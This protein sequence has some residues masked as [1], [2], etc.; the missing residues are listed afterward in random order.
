[1]RTAHV[2][3]SVHLALLKAVMPTMVLKFAKVCSSRAARNEAQVTADTQ[4]MGFT[5]TEMYV[6]SLS[7]LGALDPSVEHIGARNGRHA[8]VPAA[9]DQGAR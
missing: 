2:A 7:M 4:D 1:M 3:T 6:R 9:A 8:L 5:D